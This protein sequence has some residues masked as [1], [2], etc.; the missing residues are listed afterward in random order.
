MM[1]KAQHLTSF[2][3]GCKCCSDINA[4]LLL[5]IMKLII[6]SQERYYNLSDHIC[7]LIYTTYGF[8][9]QREVQNEAYN[10]SDI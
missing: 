7:I 3:S 8:I 10:S 2:T 5:L 4:Y 6:V 9:M 1:D